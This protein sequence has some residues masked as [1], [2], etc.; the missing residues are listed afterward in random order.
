MRSHLHPFDYKRKVVFIGSQFKLQFGRVPR[1]LT[2]LFL[3]LALYI[4]TT[5]IRMKSKTKTLTSS[6]PFV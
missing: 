3:K 2:L 5:L 4:S 6:C 1:L